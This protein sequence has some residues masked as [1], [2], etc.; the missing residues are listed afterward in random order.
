MPNIE[1]ASTSP[2]FSLP[3]DLWHRTVDFH[4]CPS[5]ICRPLSLVSH[6]FRDFFQP[7]VFRTVLIA[8]ESSRNLDRLEEQ[9]AFLQTE[10]ILPAIKRCRIQGPRYEPGLITSEI[11]DHPAF[12]RIFPQLEFISFTEIDFRVEEFKILAKLQNVKEIKLRL[13]GCLP[14]SATLRFEATPESPLLRVH[15]LRISAPLEDR[16]LYWLSLIR[17]DQLQS[18]ALHNCFGSEINSYVN[19]SS[20]LS[21]NNFSNLRSLLVDRHHMRGDGLRSLLSRCPALRRFEVLNVPAGF[22]YLVRSEPI[23]IPTLHTLYASANDTLIMPFTTGMGMLQHVH[24]GAAHPQLVCEVLRV[25]RGNKHTL[26]SISFVVTSVDATHNPMELLMSFPNL[27]TLELGFS[28]PK[29]RREFYD[30]IYDLLANPELTFPSTLEHLAIKFTSMQ[31]LAWQESIEP[32]VT[33]RSWAMTFSKLRY[34]EVSEKKGDAV[35]YD[36]IRGRVVEEV[37]LWDDVVQYQLGT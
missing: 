18:L 5:E 1:S 10:R 15:H 28:G 29:H 23:P 8:I 14:R 33:K 31:G 35:R 2:P 30:C 3:L 6:S 9:L 32:L 24:F 12:H 25:L 37:Q 20:S 13:C 4:P 11:L 16:L 19:S 22:K 7:L 26:K 34:L 17:V 36:H 27:K 21:P